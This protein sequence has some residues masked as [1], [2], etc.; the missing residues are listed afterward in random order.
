MH[1][2][3]IEDDAVIALMIE[4]ELRDLGYSSV[5]N[6]STEEEAIEAVARRCPDLVTSDGS[7]LGGSGV[8]AVRKI[9][10]SCSVPVIL[11][12]GDPEHARRCVPDAPILAKPFSVSQL[13]AAVENAQ[14][15]SLRQRRMMR[16][17]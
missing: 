15:V 11:I 4:D 10:A 16:A 14:P 6:A 7:L 9:R 12:T 5:D 8:G 2:L 1:A 13:V 3:V 17:Y